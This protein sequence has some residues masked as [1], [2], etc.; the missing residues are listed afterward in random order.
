MVEPLKNIK[1]NIITG[2]LGAGKSTAILNLLKHKPTDER[3]AILVNEFG[4]IGI[5]GGLLAGSAASNI[6]IRE[7]PGG[8][9]CCAA[10]LPMQIAMNM[11]LAKARPDRLIIEPTGLGHP[12]EVMSVL[13]AE[14]YQTLLSL[15][16]TLTLVDARK[17]S[18]RR[19][20]EHATF[21]QQL[22]IADVIVASKTD[23]YDESDFPNLEHYLTKQALL[24]DR[25]LIST[26]VGNLDLHWLNGNAKAWSRDTAVPKKI[27]ESPEPDQP[28][29]FPETGFIR[30]GNSGEGFESFG[31]LFE[32]GFTF[33]HEK[34]AL[35]LR[36][37]SADRLK[38]ILKT[39][40][41]HTG[42][43]S[44]G[45]LLKEIPLRTLADSRIE[46]ITTPGF[47]ANAFEARLL[48][49]CSR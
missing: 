5:D 29:E 24:E 19:Y 30:L 27:T 2:F 48:M 46:I 22:E 14:H 35:L 3:W 18:D 31:W 25:Q 15:Q 45:D 7:V 28:T 20:T 17:V 12:F 47:D 49:T 9:M 43:N 26:N 36:Q 4:E 13:A 32:P 44:A 23:L 1:T 11:L 34:V 10:G 39:D 16:T 38:A 37:T 8:C 21:N 33:N 40:T 42:F 6:F 41:G